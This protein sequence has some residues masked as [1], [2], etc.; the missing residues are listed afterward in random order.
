M[1]H[2]LACLAIHL[3]AG[4]KTPAVTGLRF[5]AWAFR[6]AKDTAPKRKQTFIVSNLRIS[7][8]DIKAR[9]EEGQGVPFFDERFTCRE[10]LKVQKTFTL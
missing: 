3:A 6:D 5:T 7:L 4:G 8:Q 10:V 1:Q 2:F 9:V